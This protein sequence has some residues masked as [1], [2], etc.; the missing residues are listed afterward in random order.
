MKNQIDVK[1]DWYRFILSICIIGL[2]ILNAD[3]TQAQTYPPSC[4]VTMPYN[5]AYFK[6]GSDI[7]IHV[8]STDIGKT[9][10][11]G[12][13]TMV[14]F[15]E[16]ETLLGKAK[17]NNDYTYKYVWKDVSAGTYNIKA[18]ATN[19][20]GVSFT[21]VGVIITVGTNELTSKGMSACK[22]KYLANI[23]SFSV[24]DNYDNYWNGITSENSCKWGSVESKRDTFN[25]SGA[26]LAY[27][28][29]KD[30]NMVFRYH[31]LLW[32]SQYPKWLIKLNTEE[33]KAKIVTH[34]KTVAARFPLADQIDLLNEQLYDHQRDNQKFRELL[35]GPGTTAKDFGWQIWLFEQARAIFPNTKLVLND[36]GLEG[37]LKAIKDQLELFKVLRDRGLVDGF[38]TQA[39]CFNV[40]KPTA[41]TIKISLDLMATSGLPIYATELDMN[42][43]IKGRQANDSLQLISF[44]KAFPVFWEHPA[45]AGITFWGYIQGATWISGTGFVNKEGIENPSMIWL[46]SYM[47][48]RPNVGYPICVDGKK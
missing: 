38:G 29:A 24:P 19:N 3:I 7:E 12:T 47:S 18:K 26:D 15:Y 16:D 36:Y 43:G 10:N 33:A 20:S 21:S 48:S 41:D 1:K 40:D 4:V 23:I 13:V 11:N 45:V 25:W 8:Y 28:H 32:A 42:G 27:N 2:F 31:A 44:Q 35:G 14:E 34:M 30:N 39:H 22:G 6:V 46:K 17:K 37:D 5:N 9:S